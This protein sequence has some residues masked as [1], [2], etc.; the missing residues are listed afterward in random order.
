MLD[1]R[2][3]D[4]RF[5]HLYKVLLKITLLEPVPAHVKVFISFSDAFGNNYFGTLGS[6][7]VSF[8][9]MFLPVR[10]SP[11]LW[12]SLFEH[13]WMA[14]L[15]FPVERWRPKRVCR[16][17]QVLHLDHLKVSELL[18]ANLGPFIL[19]SNPVNLPAESFDFVQEMFFQ[20]VCDK[21]IS[22]KTTGNARRENPQRGNNPIHLETT[23]IV[24]FV[25]PKYLHF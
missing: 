9:D 10:L 14:D 19:P 21:K 12:A 4:L 8:P 18:R 13:L 24:I 2:E 16:S 7:Y 5:P 25:P 3:D 1:L 20:S 17:V 6:F 23:C 11:L 22:S 15:R